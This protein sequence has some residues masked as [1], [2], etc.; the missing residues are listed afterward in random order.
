MDEYYYKLTSALMNRSELLDD[1]TDLDEFKLTENKDLFV[2][3]LRY[4]YGID[5]RK[6]INE[7]ITLLDELDKTRPDLKKFI[8]YEY[9]DYYLK[10]DHVPKLQ[11]MYFQSAIEHENRIAIQ[12]HAEFIF[13]T[14]INT[15]LDNLIALC[16]RGV[17]LGNYDCCYLLIDCYAKIRDFEKLCEQFEVL[18]AH[19]PSKKIIA[20]MENILLVKFSPLTSSQLTKFIN[21]ILSV[22]NSSVLSIIG[23]Y[24]NHITP[25]MIFAIISSVGINNNRNKLDKLL[26]IFNNNSLLFESFIN[27][28]QAL[29]NKD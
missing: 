16:K 22:N 17:E 25:D 2:L 23:K 27:N 24:I 4:K 9:S 14:T 12:E 15:E 21:I 1:T 6:D 29:H 7:Y 19:Y 20:E 11:E 18:L 26:Y 8:H 3:A 5:C 10:Y 28:V 13:D